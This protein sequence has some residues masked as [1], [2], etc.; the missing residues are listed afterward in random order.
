VWKVELSAYDDSVDAEAVD[1]ELMTA[2]LVVL[3]GTSL[4][5]DAVVDATLQTA[6]ERG[7]THK[8]A[9]G[10]PYDELVETIVDAERYDASGRASVTTP[11]TTTGVFRE[12]A[13]AR[14]ASSLLAK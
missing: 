7:L 14:N 8:M 5:D 12:S 10:R 4:A 11:W 13:V 1:T 3:C 9:A 6:F 2:V